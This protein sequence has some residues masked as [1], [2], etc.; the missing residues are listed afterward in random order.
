MDDR[1]KAAFDAAGE[2]VKQLLA[3][4]TGSIGAA[5]VL[6]DDGDVPGIDLQG[7]WGVYFGLVFLALSVLG[8]LFTLGMLAGQLGASAAEI[9]NPSTYSPKV[10]A[11]AGSQLGFFGLGIL[12]LVGAAII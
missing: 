1:T 11:M 10:R 12:S 7:N 9:P 3:L 8:G 2:S 5:I 6:F 4:G